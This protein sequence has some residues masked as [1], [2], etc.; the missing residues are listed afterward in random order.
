VDPSELSGI[1]RSEGLR[2][3]DQI[4]DVFGID[5]G[6]NIAYAEIVIDGQTN[7]R[8]AVSGRH[9][10]PGTVPLSDA[11]MFET[12]IVRWDRSADAEVKLLEAIALQL[13]QTQFEAAEIRLFSERPPSS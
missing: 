2:E 4:R 9:S 10:P 8:I 3:V 6:E 13:R 11:P 5:E 7:E 1:P 12:R